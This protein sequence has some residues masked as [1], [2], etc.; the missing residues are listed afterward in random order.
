MKQK[1]SIIIPCR[2]EESYIKNLITQLVTQIPNDFDYEIIIADGRST[3]KTSSILSKCS[4]E[5][6]HIRI[7]DNPEKIVSTGLNRAIKAAQGDI[8]IRIDVH[9]EY[10]YDYINNCVST[11]INSKADNVGGPWCAKGKTWLQKAIALGFQSPFSSGGARSHDIHFEGE[12]DSVYLGCWYKST[13]MDIGLFDEELVRNQDDELNLR[14]VRQGLTVWQSPAIKSFY[15]PRSSLFQLF[16]Q[17]SQYGYWKVRVIQKHH[18]PASM[19][20]LVPSLFVI[21]L[22]ISAILSP[23]SKMAFTIF[24]ASTSLYLSINIIVSIITC[25]KFEN[26]KYLFAIPFI[27]ICF[28]FGYGW[29][30]LRGIWDFIILKQ[31]SNSKYQKLTR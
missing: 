13:L 2:N 22:A 25:K 23:F 18:L 29:G 17:Y 10:A 8:I 6:K 1:I 14:L 15:F 31:S 16:K 4:H 7:I 19:R 20:H 12:V 21:L 26:I 28:H 11:L 27:F 30:F 24:I 3:D 9:T 5:N